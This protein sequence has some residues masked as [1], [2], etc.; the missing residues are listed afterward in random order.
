MFAR[1]QSLYRY[2]RV[3]I[4]GGCDIN[5]VN[6]SVSDKVGEFLIFFR[7]SETVRFNGFVHLLGN[8]VAKS[9][10]FN[11]FHRLVS[12]H[13]DISHSAET[14]DTYFQGFHIIPPYKKGRFHVR[15]NFLNYYN[16]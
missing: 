7:R 12:L 13:M 5:R 9:D 10:D 1:V 3:K 4:V 8:D 2:N 14:D 6:V 15:F 11:V 16:R